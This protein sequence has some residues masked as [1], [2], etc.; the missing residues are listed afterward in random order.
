M[1]LQFVSLSLCNIA[2]P[3]EAMSYRSFFEICFKCMLFLPRFHN[4]AASM[5]NSFCLWGRGGS[6]ESVNYPT[7]Y[8]FH[9]EKYLEA[10]G[11]MRV[12]GRGGGRGSN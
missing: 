5:C 3:I 8:L 10:K 6:H 12:N 11:T 4:L 2:Y 7:N 1:T 9:Y